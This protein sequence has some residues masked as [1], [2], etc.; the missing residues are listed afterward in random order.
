MRTILC[1]LFCASLFLTACNN[2]QPSKDQTPA[3]N[4]TAAQSTP[5]TATQSPYPGIPEALRKQLLETTTSVDMIFYE[6]PISISQN[7]RNS[8]INLLNH[9]TPEPAQIPQG[10]KAIGRVSYQAD[11]E[12]FAEADMYLSEQCRFFVFIENNKP[13]Y[14][15]MMSQAGFNFL[16]QVISQAKVVPKQ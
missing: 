16:N 11:G 10:C 1:Y 5:Q 8:I 6:L 13:K 15:N 7:E 2:E 4:N 3:Q 9:I 14:A 12:L